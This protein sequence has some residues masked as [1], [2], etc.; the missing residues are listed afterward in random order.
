MSRIR[1]IAFFHDP[2]HKALA[3]AAGKNH[4]QVA[5][6]LAFAFGISLT[7]D[8]FKVTKGMDILASST[9]RL[10]LPKGADKDP[11]FQVMDFDK[12]SFRHPFSG[13][14]IPFNLTRESF[15]QADRAL[16][17]VLERLHYETKD[18]SEAEKLAYLWHHLLR[19]LKKK[20][21]GIP[22]EL[23]P[24]DTRVPDHTI[25]DHLKLTTSTSAVWHE[26]TSYTTVSLFIWTVGPVQ[27]FIKQARKAQDFWAG[28]F[29]LS[30]LTF[31]AI[32]KVIQR[33]GPTVVIYPDL[34]AHPWI[35]QENPFETIRP[36]I[37]NRFVALI[38]END[39]EVLKEIGKE[40]DQAVKTQLK[41]W[42][43]K[44]LG[45]LKLA[46]STAYRKIIDR[47]LESAFAS[48]WIAL[49][50]PQSDSEKKD[51]E[52]AQLLLE[53]VLSSQKVSAVESILSFTKNQNT[54][55]EPNVG[56][57]FGFLY[58]YA[59]KAL[60]ARKSLRDKLFGEPEPGNP[61]KASSNE[62]VERCHL[63]GER[64]AVVVKRE[65]NGEFV[66]QYFDETNFEWVTIPNVGNIGAR[67]LPENEALCAVCLI[68]R[69]LPKIIEE[70]DIPPNYSFP[71]VTDVAVADLLEFLYADSEVSA[72]LQQF[73][74]AVAK[75][76][77]GTT[78][79]PKIRPIPRISNTIGKE[80]TE[81]EWFFEASL[82]KEVIERT[83]GAD[84]LE[85]DVK[86]AQNALN[87]LLKKI[88]R[89]PCPYYA[90]IAIDGDKMGKWLAGEIEEAA[91]KKK[92]EFSD[93]SNIYHTKVWRNLPEDF[94]K[95]ILETFRGT[96]PVTPAYHASIARALQTFALKIA[97]QIIEEQYLGQLI[98]SG[99]DDILALVNLRDLWDVLR[100]LRLAYSGRIRV[101]SDSNSFWRIE[102][103]KTNETGVV[104]TPD[105]HWL[106]MGP[107]ASLS[108][109]IV[110]AHYK[111]PLAL[112]VKKGFEMERRAKND[113]GR[114]AFSLTWVKHSGEITL[115]GGNWK[116]EET[117][118]TI[119]KSKQI[120]D[121]FMKPQKESDRQFWLSRRFLKEIA[122]LHSMIYAPVPIAQKEASQTD[123]K[124]FN[125][126]L[127]RA[128]NRHSH[129]VTKLEKSRKKEIQQKIY[130]DLTS[131][132]A[133]LNNDF[134]A[135]FNL[136]ETGL[137]YTR[138][139][140]PD[141]EE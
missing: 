101:S 52:N 83:L 100:L 74:K 54:L 111:T 61:E 95:T 50:L 5:K 71:S 23:L 132:L 30:L 19:E 49:P 47:Q 68:K 79:S 28:S 110:I 113:L 134:Q 67:E 133:L 96:R 32:E 98:Y 9:E 73:E 70:I 27:S 40:C 36:T 121:L 34:Q 85:N 12:I 33:Y 125:P 131:L 58:S 6:E 109:G 126:R 20:E 45:E 64:N 136:I 56:T 105:G 69:F 92:I 106:T 122:D 62:R 35:L 57:L 37:P 129:F 75:L 90:F 44:V 91:N 104:K 87:K 84:V 42:V 107:L 63:C 55:Y 138:F 1:L 17:E 25:W 81:G 117:P 59:E 99:G 141:R 135:F 77:E 15:E 22:W 82:Q 65:I 21:P 94:K 102:P 112:V 128:V 4:E 51:Y 86:E 114:D 140:N 18:K 130:E 29:I 13:R 123:L 139:V 119:E 72:E 14:E 11:K 108:A 93:S 8:D 10:V 97:P 48:Y 88:D 89:K 31:K 7:D 76:H 78:V 38:P 2:I 66:V 103:N 46:N 3:L 53:K 43:T 16:K 80:I 115:S 124:L 24:A 127:Q 116:I 60:A 120:F 26:G 41:S 39:H 118:D 137:L